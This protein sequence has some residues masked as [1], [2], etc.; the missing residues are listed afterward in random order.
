MK[1][2]I[3]FAVFGLA[4]V[5]CG[6]S[7]VEQSN[8]NNPNI[9]VAKLFDHEGCSVYRFEDGGNGTVYYTNCEGS[10]QFRQGKHQT[11]VSTTRIEQ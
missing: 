9:S 4:L 1:K 7:P 10:A 2:F 5:G 8:T 3:A 6:R 11:Q